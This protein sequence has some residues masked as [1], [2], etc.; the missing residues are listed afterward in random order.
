MLVLTELW[1]LDSMFHVTAL[2][3]FHST[4]NSTRVLNLQSKLLLESSRA[5]GFE[6]TRENSVLAPP[7]LSGNIR[8]QPYWTI[9]AWS[10]L[11]DGERE[12]SIYLN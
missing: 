10:S 4:A 6:T 2:I 9:F 12:T 5:N 1:K 8:A 3:V 7:G 11:L